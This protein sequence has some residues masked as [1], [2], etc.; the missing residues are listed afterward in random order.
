MLED[1]QEI[2]AYG[3]DA[4]ILGL[5]EWDQ[6]TIQ[7]CCMYSRSIVGAMQSIDV[8]LINHVTFSW[9][10]DENNSEEMRETIEVVPKTSWLRDDT[11]VEANQSRFYG[12]GPGQLSVLNLWWC[13]IPELS[14]G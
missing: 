8:D 6:W 12:G 3:K 14:Y 5:L 10:T 11:K 9:E 2:N 4:R 13:R 1:D 7:V